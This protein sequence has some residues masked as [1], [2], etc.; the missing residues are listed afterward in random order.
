MKIGIDIDGVLTDSEKYIIDYG[1]K[2]CLEHNLT[3]RIN[4]KEY[5][6][7]KILGISAENGF[8]FWN[9]YLKYYITK[10]SPRENA[11]EVI[12]KLKEEGHEI[13]LITA[14]NEWGF[15]ADDC[16]KMKEYTAQW[17]KEQNIMYDKIIFTEGSKTPYCKGNYIDVMIED[18]P[19]NI[20]ELSEKL[21]VFCYNN[22]YNAD[23]TGKNITRVYSW[24]EVYDKIHKMLEK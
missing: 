7:N 12:K 4:E 14:R 24:Y 2:F 3:Y 21:P 5:D 1:V 15:K 6:E 10:Y 23:V 20:K 13:Y 11:A 19:K 17:L 9:E 18:S 16:G 22:P 8:K